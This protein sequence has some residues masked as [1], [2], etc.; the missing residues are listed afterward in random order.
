M[1]FELLKQSY[2]SEILRIAANNK[3]ENIRLFGSVV[4]GDNTP[5]SDID[6]LVHFQ[7]G[8]SLMDMV[9]LDEDLTKLLGCKVDVL[10]DTAIKEDLAPFILNEAQSL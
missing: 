6:F 8:A 7:K 10:S 5:D 4:R 1:N 9:G 3:A 2:R